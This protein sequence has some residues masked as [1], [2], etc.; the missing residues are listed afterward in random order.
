MVKRDRYIFVVN[1]SHTVNHLVIQDFRRIY[2]ADGTVI[3]TLTIHAVFH[4]TSDDLDGNETP[5]PGEISAEVQNFQL[6]CG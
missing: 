4:V 1:G 3:G 5:D 2:A 6:G